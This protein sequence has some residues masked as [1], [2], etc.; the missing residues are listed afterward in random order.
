MEI[1]IHGDKLKITKAMSDYI[2]EKLEKLEKYLEN[3]ENVH[4][5]VIVKVK[6]H[7]QIVEITIPLKTVILRS[8][9]TQNDFKLF[10]IRELF[11]YRDMK[12]KNALKESIIKYNNCTQR[13]ARELLSNLNI[14][15][16]LLENKF[17]TISN[18]DTIRLIEYIDKLE[19]EIS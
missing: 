18:T 3:S 9:E 16:E 2:E 1:K 17:E 8:E 5:N 4:A 11:F 12:I 7:L 14:E 13:K 19:R 6:N 10:I 15:E